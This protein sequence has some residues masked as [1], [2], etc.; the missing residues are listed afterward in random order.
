LFFKV[1]FK[2]HVSQPYV[3]IGLMLLHVQFQFWFL[4]DQST[5][6]EKLFSI[7]CFISKCYSMLDPFFHWSVQ[8]CE[9]Y[10]SKSHMY[11]Y[12]PL[13]IQKSN[14]TEFMS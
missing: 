2:T 9:P 11:V 14:F 6:K 8:H 3:T 4:R 1:S 5:F 10:I 12:T 13:I 7:I